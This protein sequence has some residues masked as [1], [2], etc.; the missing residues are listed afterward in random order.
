MEEILNTP[1]EQPAPA[2]PEQTDNAAD[3]STILG[4]F[5]SVDELQRAYTNLQSEF[6]RKSQQ[7]AQLLAKGSAGAAN[8]N[9]PKEQV[10]RDYLLSIAKKEVAPAVITTGGDVAFGAK[11]SPR[12]LADIEKVAE[13]F[14]KIKGEKIK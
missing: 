3:G 5:A 6:T 9:T 1:V 10:I 7:L 8:E 2:A 4:K 12:T 11:A 13:N 14:F